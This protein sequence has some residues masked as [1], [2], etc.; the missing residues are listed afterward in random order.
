MK[1][2]SIGNSFSQDAQRYLHKLAKASDVDLYTANLYIGGCSLERHCDNLKNEASAYELEINGEST[3]EKISIQDAIKLEKWDYITLQQA[4][5]LSFDY[6]T[7][8]PYIKVLAKYIRKNCPSAKILVHQTWGYEDGSERLINEVK[9]PTFSAMQL[10]IIKAYDKAIKLIK[11]D[12]VIPSGKAML[13]V[14]ND[15]GLKAHRDTFHASYGLGRYLLALTWFGVLTQKDIG[16]NSFNDF[17]EAVSEKDREIAI[18][19]AQKAL[20]SL[21][22]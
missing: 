9:Y 13:S 12:G 7:Y 6:K 16:D 1:I 5:Y 20:K 14:I 4:S 11:A 22:S 21:L 3:G 2:L 10:D 8:T 15:Y 17:D 18:L 19:S